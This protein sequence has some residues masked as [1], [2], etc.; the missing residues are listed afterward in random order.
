MYLGLLIMLTSPAFAIYAKLQGRLT[1][2]PLLPLFIGLALFLLRR[3]VL[4]RT[5]RLMGEIACWPFPFKSGVVHGR[6]IC[7]WRRRSRVGRMMT[8][9]FGRD[10]I[11]NQKLNWTTK[12]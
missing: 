4:V 6:Q 5:L 12:R 2:W 1:L 8:G 11:L 7:R 3:H 9:N 10:R